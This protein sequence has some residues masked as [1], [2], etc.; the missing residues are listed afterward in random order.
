MN[1]LINSL[2]KGHVFGTSAKREQCYE[3]LR[4]TRNAWDTNLCKANPKF[5]SVNLEAGGGGQFAVLAHDQVGKLPN[6]MPL[7]TGHTGAVLD[8]DWNPYNDYI[9]AS[10]AEDCKVMIWSIPEKGLTE[11]LNTPVLSFDKHTRKVGHVMF[12]PSAENVMLS[13][14]ADLV[15]KLYDLQ[16]GV[17]KQDITGHMDIVNSITWSYDGSLIATTCKDKKIRLIDPRANK[18]VQEA[19]THQGI[20]GTRVCWLGD[21]DRIL[22]TGFSKTSDRQY[23]IWDAKNMTEPLKCENLDTASGGLIPHFDNDTKMLYLAGKGDGNIRYWEFVDEAPYLH[24]LSEYKSSDPQR[25]IAFLPKRAC[26]ISDCEV[27]RVFK[28][29]P[30]RVEPISFK[31]P[32]KSDQFQADIFPDTVGD[33]PAMTSAEWFE[34]NN[35]KPKL[36]SLE[37]GFQA[38]AKKDFVTEAPVA[39]NEARDPLK[40]PANE[41]EYQDAFHSLRKENDGLKNELAQ[42][43]VRIRQLELQL[44]NLLSNGGGN[45]KI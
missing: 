23:M 35:A 16:K 13:S 3:N 22:T 30:D 38:S 34:G 5:I 42:K 26:S 40:N 43:D 20:K 45:A 8:T 10:C 31:V 24:V 18:I 41:R 36:V 11:N 32:R 12:H 6:D 7:V 33:I 1:G 37:K 21:S 39:S 19:N 15:I 29:H 28:V 4:V 44:E 27:A 25:G 14:G 2:S 17:E 9:V